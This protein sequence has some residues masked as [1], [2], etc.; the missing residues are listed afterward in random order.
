MQ[1]FFNPTI[2]YFS[3]IPLTTQQIILLFTKSNTNHVF[4][5]LHSL[6]DPYTN[7]LIP[8]IN[9]NGTYYYQNNQLH[10]DND[11]PA[12]ILP[13]GTQSYYK[14]GQ[15]HRDNDLPAII[16]S[17]GTLEYYKNGHQY[18]PNIE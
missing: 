1:A 5:Q 14:N 6:T 7:K 11:L 16:H 15:L 13:N 2:T 9:S 10:R 12:I 8:T 18:T 3:T 17:N 4:N